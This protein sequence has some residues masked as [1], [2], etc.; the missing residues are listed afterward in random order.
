MKNELDLTSLLQYPLM[1]LAKQIGEKYKCIIKP[2]YELICVTLDNEKILKGYS[3]TFE[4]GAILSVQFSSFSYCDNRF[5][6]QKDLMHFID[7]SKM[8]SSSQL[9]AHVKPT[10][11]LDSKT[12]EIAIVVNNSLLWLE[13]QNDHVAGWQTTEQILKW[14]DMA[15][16]IDLTIL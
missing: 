5:V 10:H 13:E 6:P 16:N 2:D 3:V 15:A 8:G 9:K 14:A 11:N 12:A 4:N 7:M 1:A